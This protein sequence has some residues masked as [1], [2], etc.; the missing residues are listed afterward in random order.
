MK[1][2]EHYKRCLE[3]ALQHGF[4]EQI[5]YFAEKIETLM[6]DEL[7]RLRNDVD[8]LENKALKQTVP[9]IE[10]LLIDNGII[11]MSDQENIYL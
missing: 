1:T 4:H 2:I 10:D 11:F 9:T 7:N 5:R 3:I 6:K 8:D